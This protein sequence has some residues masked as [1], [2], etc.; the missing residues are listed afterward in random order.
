MI[1]I[2]KVQNSFCVSL[3]PLLFFISMPA[4]AFGPPSIQYNDDGIRK[5]QTEDYGSAFD[6]FAK[7]LSR[8]PFNPAFHLNLGDTFMK[9]GELDKAASEFEAVEGSP[10]STQQE[11]FK[12]MF[13]AGNAAVSAK[14]IP[15]ALKYYQ[16]ALDYDPDSL[17]VKTN[18]E[19]ALASQ[20]GGGKGD[21][22]DQKDKKDQ[23]D[24]KLGGDDKKQQ[25][26]NK[27]QNKDQQKEPDKGPG[28]KPT[29]HGFKS[30]AL[31]ENDVR[32]ILEEL[33]R[34][35]EEIRAKQYKERRDTPEREIEKDW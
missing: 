10:K 28:P 19:L 2:K 1:K 17:E 22:K 14:D 13:N 27:D 6:D 23:K 26:Q 35:E 18:I 8:D 24:Q 31:N 7:A 21:D 15:K 3:M 34:Q 25:D 9:N 11:K 20:Q 12:A 32:R 4:F 16:R 30:Q 33:K 5:Y 29:P